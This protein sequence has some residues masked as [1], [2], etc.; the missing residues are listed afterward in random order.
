MITFL[1][2]V[3]PASTR[4][5]KRQKS[6]MEPTEDESDEYQKHEKSDAAQEKGMLGDGGATNEKRQEY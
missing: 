5:T 1:V 6:R 3:P 2:L 4:V